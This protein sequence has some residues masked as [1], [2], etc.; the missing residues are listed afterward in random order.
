MEF[1]SQHPKAVEE[2]IHLHVYSQLQGDELYQ[3]I[4][5]K[6]E[7]IFG[8]RP[9]ML[10]PEMR[11]ALASVYYYVVTIRETMSDRINGFVVFM[12]GGSRSKA[13][14]KI[15]ILAVDEKSRRRGVAGVLVN[16]LCK[17]GISCTK[18]L[19]STRPSNV[20]AIQAYKKWG[21][22]EDLE[23]MK[24]AQAHF[25]SGHWIHLVRREATCK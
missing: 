17:I 2:D 15:T 16:S 8:M 4:R 10:S 6:L 18:L 7:G 5:L 21:F 14:Y 9:K 25:V 23:A 19:V 13:E 20:S 11:E 3:A 22:G 12:G 24:S 1:L